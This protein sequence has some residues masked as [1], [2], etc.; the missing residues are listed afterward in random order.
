MNPTNRTHAARTWSAV[1]AAAALALP[2]TAWGQTLTPRTFTRDDAQFPRTITRTHDD[3]ALTDPYGFATDYSVVFVPARFIPNEAHGSY[4][5]RI[6]M[7]NDGHWEYADMHSSTVPL[8]VT[9]NYPEPPQGS[10]G[11]STIHVDIRQVL[12]GSPVWNGNLQVITLPNPQ[13][14]YVSPQGD[15][16]T[17]YLSADG[18]LDR[19]LIV[20]EGIDN[21]Q[22]SWPSHYFGLLDQ[23]IQQYL[24]PAGF[25]VFVYNYADGGADIRQNAM[26]LLGAILQVNKIATVPTRVL[27]ISMGGVVARYALAWAEQ[28]GYPHGCD[29]F[30]SAD[31]P[32]QGA[33]LS[34][35]FQDWLRNG[36]LDSPF[37]D[38]IVDQ[39]STPAS[40]QL[41][42]VNRFDTGNAV[43][44]K[45][46]EIDGSPTYE[47]FFTE[48][49]ALNG[50]GYPHLSTNIGVS[51][52]Q[53]N[54][55]A[56]SISS[57]QPEDYIYEP[58]VQLYLQG[59]LVHTQY[60]DQFDLLAGSWQ[61]AFARLDELE[62]NS[63]LFS[64]FK[65]TVWMDWRVDFGAHPPGFV[66]ANSALDLWDV[67][68]GTGDQNGDIQG[69]GSTKFNEIYINSTENHFHDDFPDALGAVVLG[70]LLAP[71]PPL[72]VPSTWYPTIQDGVNASNVPYYQHQ[73]HVLPGTYT[74]TS[75]RSIFGFQ[76]HSVVF[77]KDQV[78]LIADGGPGQVIIDADVA[79]GCGMFGFGSSN[80]LIEGFTFRNC[81][82]GVFSM[83]TPQGARAVDLVNCE[84]SGCQR[85]FRLVGGT[86]TITGGSVHNSV[87][88][89]IEIAGLSQATVTG[90]TARDN[91]G[92]GI[93][94]EEQAYG[95]VRTSD[96]RHNV[97]G[98][99]QST[100][101]GTLLVE[102]S[103]FSGN[104][105]YGIYLA[106]STS[107]VRGNTLLDNPTGISLRGSS[108]AV[109]RNVI[110]RGAN[111]LEAINPAANTLVSNTVF[112]QTSAGI[113]LA[114]AAA[115]TV[116][117]NIVAAAGVGIYCSGSGT[118]TFSCNDVYGNGTNYSGR[119]DP[120]GS[121]GNISVN[122]RFC[123]TADDDYHI[124]T[125]SPCQPENN[126]CDLIGALEGVCPPDPTQ[127][128]VEFY[129]VTGALAV[130]PNPA[131]YDGGSGGDMRFNV[132]VRDKTGATM[133][134]VRV[135]WVMSPQ[136][137]RCSGWVSSKFTNSS[138][139][140]IL[141]AQG[142]GYGTSE[143]RAQVGSGPDFV[144]LT[145]N[146]TTRSPDFDRASGN[147]VVNTSDLIVFADEFNHVVTTL[148]HDYD[149]SGSV[150]Q[151]DLQVFAM[152][153]SSANS[154]TV[155][156]GSQPGGGSGGSLGGLS[157]KVTVDETNVDLLLAEVEGLIAAGKGFDNARQFVDR[158]RAD[159]A[160]GAAVTELGVSPAI[161]VGVSASPNPS[162]AG[163]TI[164]FNLPGAAS[165]E[166][167]I[168]DL[169]GRLVRMIDT[170]ANASMGTA[171]WDGRDQGGRAVV[172]GIYFLSFRAPT[173]A[174]YVEKL[175]IQR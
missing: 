61:P 170:E 54:L 161:P 66:W 168:F 25:D 165:V 53:G 164:Q 144:S 93:L 56:H 3:H 81:D 8:T 174:R 140:T 73:V 67:T 98:V 80:V 39:L 169:A 147:G 90:L 133:P 82:Y 16:L 69:W 141:D 150:D 89:G 49:N 137:T 65:F 156:G 124:S 29:M 46:D 37:V 55:A 166:G 96:L 63:L 117:A 84:F 1:L 21:A 17:G 152:A 125:A 172:P 11:T 15:A 108:G 104:T 129:A 138:G 95:E 123:N 155:A 87:S 131:T 157:R 134:N 47:G 146:V 122:P 142:G 76:F 62:G 149:N 79:D 32:Q 151:S 173:G 40:K 83:L 171:T 107:T 6:D 148:Y 113:R 59:N 45:D 4:A 99:S 110:V 100:T 70:R 5:I 154:C 112:G 10:T 160:A 175:V 143:I 88:N 111:G 26:G 44:N 86:T 57:C 153:Y 106:G 23:Q 135:S 103:T 34:V 50:N 7:N 75:E 28:H 13:M 105:G 118:I 91:G 130:V 127:S 35:E 94:F 120:T 12:N 121:G 24:R 77:L 126:A 136:M 64:F 58:F 19:P 162:R 20:V 22:T 43:P 27:G 119:P 85:G 163:V 60:L 38:T 116:T 9:F 159:R 2:L 18:I 72:V 109:S 114:T 41:L 132:T 97:T 52:G 74:Q 71:P 158:V 139:T 92:A 42:R 78:Q 167:R 14:T 51:N 31:A 128:T 101:G 115:N 145:G 68:W 33:W 102:N 48:L 36:G 30:V